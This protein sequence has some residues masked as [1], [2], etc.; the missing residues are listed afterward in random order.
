LQREAGELMRDLQA[1]TPPTPDGTFAA[2]KS[3]QFD[4]SVRRAMHEY[5]DALAELRQFRERPMRD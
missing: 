4:K 5:F 2:A 3:A 1:Q